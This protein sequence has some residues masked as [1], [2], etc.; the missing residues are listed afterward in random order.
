[1]LK[2]YIRI[3][4]GVILQ[5]FIETIYKDYSNL[6]AFTVTKRYILGTGINNDELFEI[7]KKVFENLF[8]KLVN[9]EEEIN[10]LLN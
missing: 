10:S 4:E 5:L 9:L 7:P 6:Q 8:E 2:F 3:K 1:M